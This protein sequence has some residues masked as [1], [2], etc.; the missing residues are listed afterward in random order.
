VNSEQS[1]ANE[2]Q[3]VCHSRSKA[4]LPRNFSNSA[5][6]RSPFTVHTQRRNTFIQ[7]RV[8]QEQPFDATAHAPGD[9]EGL[10]LFR[11]MR[12]LV[13][14]FEPLQGSDHFFASRKPRAAAKPKAEAVAEVEA[15][16]DDTPA[17]EPAA[18]DDDTADKAAEPSKP[19]KRGWWSR[20]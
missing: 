13:A 7:R 11:Q 16:P 12:L 6:N 20:G 2:R 14:L 1:P 8:T 9:T 4:A 5:Y 3:T 18:N 15:K 19:K 10:E 17:P